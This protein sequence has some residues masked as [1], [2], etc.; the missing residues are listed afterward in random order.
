MS[1]NQAGE[2][3]GYKWVMLTA[4]MLLAASVWACW[5]AQAPLLIE[6]WGRPPLSISVR[7]VGL[8]LSLPG[9]V[10][11]I[12]AVVTGRWV[13]TIGVR[14]MMI[15]SGVAGCIGFG[16]RPLFPASFLD[17]AILTPIGGYAVCVLT[18]CLP[19]TMIQ[20]FGHEKGHTYIGIGAGSYFVG[21]GLGVLVTANLLASLGA[22]GVFT[23]WSIVMVATT[24]IWVIFARDR[25]AASTA[26]R[27]A[28]GDEIRK[29]MHT[30][31]AWL[32]LVYAMF[33]SGLTVCVMQYLPGQMTLAR[34]LPPA[35]AGSVVGIY[36]IAMGI[37]LAVLPALAGQIGKKRISVILCSITLLIL[38]VYMIVP[39]WTT[40]S[41]LIFAVAWGFFFQAP[42]A[43]GLA[44][45]ESLP[46]V[47]PANVG[48]A[49]GVWI[50]AVNT[51]VFFLP[52]IF[53]SILASTGGPGGT[54]GLW[55]ILIGY[56]VALLAMLA[57]RDNHVIKVA[58]SDSPI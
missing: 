22:R 51:G 54:G 9:L 34:H 40:T 21:I 37:G 26:Q 10:A 13:D 57:A 30:G 14:K 39:N 49:A 32:M 43:T 55:A 7:W 6:Y 24:I 28:F 53:G 16:L 36:A 15:L 29:V 2:P 25:A 27:A 11:V 50:M 31:S 3:T 38:I 4:Y 47:T 41:L 5:F 44:L 19:S 48:V 33:I 8:L 58:T 23:V 18:A 12:L 1:K 45:M 56:G 42:W 35:L 20:W 46:G 52:L 17:Q